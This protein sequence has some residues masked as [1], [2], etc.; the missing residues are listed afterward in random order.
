MPRESFAM[1]YASVIFSLAIDG[2]FDY[3]VLP[4]LSKKIKIGTR[5]WVSFGTQKV[6]GYVIALSR[7]TKIKQLKEILE[8]IDEEPIL[9]KNM[10][11]V[12]RK[13]SEYYCCSWGQV[14]DTALPEALRKGRR[15]P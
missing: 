12:T 3:I 9:D 13:I 2:P 15:L 4:P 10:L 8:V 1:L 5:V 11:L 14:I 7:Q 6:L